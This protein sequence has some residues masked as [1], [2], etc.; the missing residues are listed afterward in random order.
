MA[1]PTGNR[2]YPLTTGAN[3]NP[4]TNPIGLVYGASVAG[5]T[6]IT[7]SL[8]DAVTLEA[9]R[10]VAAARTGST[11]LQILGT[12][13]GS[14]VTVSSVDVAT[15]IATLSANSTLTTT[16]QV[17]Q[18]FVGGIP[19]QQQP[20]IS[21]VLCTNATGTLAFLDANGSTLTLV[22]KLVA[23]AVYNFTMLS[24]TT[25]TA[26]VFIGISE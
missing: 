26:G 25:A 6:K 4:A 20:P 9:A 21:A 1:Q 2:F 11:G 19:N 23:G 5:T 18:Y 24:V 22:N 3:Y 8:R 16:N 7:L 15:G 12:T 17:F 13:N 10:A 14:F